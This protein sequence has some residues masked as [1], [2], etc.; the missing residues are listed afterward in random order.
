MLNSRPQIGFLQTYNSQTE[1]IATAKIIISTPCQLPMRKHYQHHLHGHPSTANTMAN[2]NN[3]EEMTLDDNDSIATLLSTNY[4]ITASSDIKEHIL[5]FQFQPKTM[6]C[7]CEVLM[8]HYTIL[9]AI[10]HYFPE[11]IIYDNHGNT[12]NEFSKVNNYAS[13]LRHFNLQH[14]KENQNKMH[15]DM[16]LVFHQ[17]HSSMPLSEICC[18]NVIEHLLKKVSSNPQLA[19][20]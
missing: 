19:G 12:L 2:P 3:Q 14:V 1:E 6:K 11:A 7:N 17:S 16:Y 9:D 18:H 8:T 13:Y 4:N 20:K 10:S 15:G 5:K